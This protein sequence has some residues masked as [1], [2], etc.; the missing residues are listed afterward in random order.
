ME[1][2]HS[3][4]WVRNSNEEE[5]EFRPKPM[6]EVGG[7]PVLWHIMKILSHHGIRDF[8]VA[9]GIGRTSS[10]L[11]LLLRGP[12]QR[13]HSPPRRQ[14]RI[15]IHR[16]HSE[17]DWTVTVADT[18]N[19]TPTGGRIKR[20]QEFVA[21]A[22]RFLVAYGDGIAD[23][24][25]GALLSFHES[26]GRL[27]TLTAVRPPSRFGL[28]EFGDDH[29]VQGFREK[30]LLDDWI[31]VGFFVFEQAVF[32]YLADDSILE[33]APLE[34][35]AADGQLMVFKHDGFWQ[36]M[37]TYREA[38]LLNS[39]WDDGKAPWRVWE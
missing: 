17:S 5:T 10:G 9:R 38:Q 25:I 23:V 8:V 11:F 2:G 32:D 16:R 12:E 37:D 21:H 13:L 39:L 26:H 29:E 36:P 30:P 18:G 15:E 20:I 14:P 34:N 27:A 31:N 24:N 33:Q 7:R 6:V 28:V 4:W 3:R 1:G 35:L 19:V 22:P